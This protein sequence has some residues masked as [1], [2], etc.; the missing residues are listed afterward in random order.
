MHLIQAGLPMFLFCGLGVWVVSS[1]IEGKNAERDVFQGRI[2]KYVKR[3]W[4]FQLK[5][6]VSTI[7]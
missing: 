3:F 7:V 1:G 2:S 4:S 6:N 5:F